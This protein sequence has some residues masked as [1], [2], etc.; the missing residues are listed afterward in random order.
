[1]GTSGSGTGADT[2]KNDNRAPQP[3]APGPKTFLEL[4]LHFSM[5]TLVH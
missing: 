1:M 3:A 2:P 4:T 5:G